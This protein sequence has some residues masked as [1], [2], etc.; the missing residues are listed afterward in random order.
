MWLVPSSLAALQLLDCSALADAS[1]LQRSRA[2]AG[3]T[4]QA[5][6]TDLTVMRVCTYDV[7]HDSITRDMTRAAFTRDMIHDSR[8]IHMGHKSFGTHLTVMRG[9]VIVCVST[10]LYAFLCI[11][12]R[13]Y[14]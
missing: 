5:P 1:V 3:R 12:M 13:V 8:L 11:R 4:Y 2:F 7:S 9:F 14:I 6:R 10:H